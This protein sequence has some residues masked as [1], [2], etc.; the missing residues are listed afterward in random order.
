[1]RKQRNTLYLLSLHDVDYA[2]S[3]LLVLLNIKNYSVQEAM[4][5]DFAVKSVQIVQASFL[6]TNELNLLMKLQMNHSL[7]RDI[8]F[9]YGEIQRHGLESQCF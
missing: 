1:M 6:M 7:R 9:R 2:K 8:S 5:V 4:E 3:Q